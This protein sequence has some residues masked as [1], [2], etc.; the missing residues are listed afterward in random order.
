MDK[1]LSLM[2]TGTITISVTLSMAGA[3]LLDSNKYSFRDFKGYHQN[4]ENFRH[5][6]LIDGQRMRSQ[7]NG[8]QAEPDFEK[9]A[10]T[11]F[12]RVDTNSDKVITMEKVEATL[13]LSINEHM[14][15]KASLNT[16]CRQAPQVN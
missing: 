6:M 3:Y 8:T 12:K 4:A 11:I 1:K 5:S 14:K 10:Q 16:K 2:I 9:M 7:R 15:K 13:E